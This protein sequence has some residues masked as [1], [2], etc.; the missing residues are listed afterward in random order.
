[1]LKYYLSS[2]NDSTGLIYM[3][4]CGEVLMRLRSVLDLS[5]NSSSAAIIIVLCAQ[6]FQSCPTL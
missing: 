3:S 1:M 5:L 6:L 2:K 4:E